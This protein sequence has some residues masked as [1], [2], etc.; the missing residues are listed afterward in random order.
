MAGQHSDIE[1]ER[2]PLREVQASAPIKLKET[3]SAPTSDEGE[4]HSVSADSESSTSPESTVTP[5]L[6]A[7]PQLPN[8]GDDM[9]VLSFIGEG[10]MGFVYRVLDKRIDKEFAVKLLRKELARDKTKH[11][12]F[13]QE[14]DSATNLDH[15]NLV[16]VYNHAIA[17]DGTPYM[18]MDFVNGSSLAEML[19]REVF[20][21]PMRANSLFL[22]ICDGVAHAH[23]NGVVH[24]DLKPSN[25]L[26]AQNENVE[27]TKVSDFGI[28]QVMTDDSQ[29][30]SQTEE[31]VGSLPYM[32]PEHCRGES[33]DYRSDV[34]SLGCL[35]YEVL[36]GKPPFVGENP[37]KTIMKH[38]QDKP[39]RLKS[40]LTRLDIPEGLEKIVLHCLEK[41]PERRYQNTEELI[42]DLELV[43]DGSEPHIAI[44]QEQAL[45]TLDGEERQKSLRIW[46]AIGFVGLCLYFTHL[47]QFDTLNQMGKIFQSI[48]N[49]L[50]VAVCLY[51]CNKVINYQKQIAR[52]IEVPTQ[53]RAGDHWLSLAALTTMAGL[54]FIVAIKSISFI[55]DNQIM[56]L[57]GIFGVNLTAQNALETDIFVL[58]LVIMQL[59]FLIWY[60]RQKSKTT[61]QKQISGW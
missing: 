15:P 17:P 49:G 22:Q 24:L 55:A 5:N 9:E 4:I 30:I 57:S 18:V 58:L 38:I 51:F 19:T 37:V 13:K 14:V 29:Q 33:L 61:N 34:Y 2:A 42:K 50:V 8:I 16:T 12:R 43:R 53:I 41:N 56:D 1:K 26:V 21:E 39:P 44:Q 36:T 27:I 54:L 25:V 60:F 59:T 23:L 45:K 20:L 28:A 48:G 6:Q 11:A 52:R 7:D 47:S 32:S 46:L 40:R 3:P 35:M 10:G 31:I